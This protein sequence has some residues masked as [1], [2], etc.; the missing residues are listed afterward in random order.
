MVMDSV[1]GSVDRA[2]LAGPRFHR[3]L[4]TGRRQVLTG[5]RP[6]GR[7]GPSRLATRVT[8]GRV[9]RGTIGGPLTGAQM[10]SWRWRTGGGASAPS[11]YSAGAIEEGRRR[12][13]GVRC[14]TRV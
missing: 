12:G 10:I 9:R 13:E 2:G 8:T 7:S 3:G 11:G 4:H 14:S 6:N 5:A 1:H